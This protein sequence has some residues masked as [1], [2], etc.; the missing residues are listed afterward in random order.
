M[1]NESIRRSLRFLQWVTVTFLLT[2]GVLLATDV[3]RSK[4][5]LAEGLE[6]IARLKEQDLADSKLAQTV[7]DLDYLYRSAY[8]Q[9]ADKQKRG[10]L[11]LGIGFFTLCG[12]LMLELVLFQPKLKVPKTTEQLPE[13]ERRQLLVFASCGLAILVGGIVAMRMLMMPSS[14]PSSSEIVSSDEPTAVIEEIDLAAAL[15]AEKSQWPQFRGSVLPNANA[16]PAKWDFQEKWNVAIPLPGNN[17]PVIWGENIFLAGADET[18]RA[19]FCFSAQNGEL[20]WKNATSKVKEM[21]EVND[22]TGY[23]SPTLCVDAKRVYAVFATG[24]ILVCDHDGKTLWNKQLP[25]PDIA[26]G[27]A[28]SPLLMGDKLIVQYDQD[29]V[30]T[31]FALNVFTGQETWK[32]ERQSSSSWS[33]PQGL[34]VN[35]KGLIFTA[36]NKLAELFELDTGKVVWS[37]EC[38][39]GEVATTAFVAGDVIYF[40]NTGAFTGAFSAADGSILCRN[41]DVPA[42]DVSSPVKLGNQFILFGSGGTIIAID[43]KSG[44]ELYEEDLDNGF[45]SSPVV[46]GGKIAAITLDGDLLK[47]SPSEGK[48]QTEGKYSIGTKVV[49][50]PAFH[51]GGII[52]RTAENKLISLEAKP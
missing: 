37:Q 25:K 14:K 29:S 20:R 6:E 1:R 15:E 43:A 2:L 48:L 52:V 31:I 44:E 32:T 8:F 24:E 3:Y 19:I 27:Y 13:K 12:L 23:S 38:M 16:L 26:Y 18:E 39:G 17:S 9:S 28:S 7:R 40:S 34:Y 5:P 33:S 45:Y 41:D 50:T 46:V 21:P 51:Q 35:G 49:A 4:A 30:Q 10:V 36:G 47:L 11:L 22:D 42:P